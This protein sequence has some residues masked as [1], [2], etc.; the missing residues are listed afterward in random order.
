MNNFEKKFKLKSNDVASRQ[1]SLF[2]DY[3]KKKINKK[4]KNKKVKQTKKRNTIEENKQSCVIIGL[5]TAVLFERDDFRVIVINGKTICG[6]F[7]LFSRWITY[8]L[9][10]KLKPYKGR[11]SWFVEKIEYIDSKLNLSILSSLIDEE[12]TITE[13]EKIEFFNSL[14]ICL[15][16]NEEYEK[17]GNFD[18]EYLF[19]YFNNR[20]FNSLVNVSAYFKCN[21][22]SKLSQLYSE[23]EINRFS[24]TE[25]NDLIQELNLDTFQFCFKGKCPDKFDLNELN[26]EK[27]I[28]AC[29]IFNQEYKQ[30][31]I[32]KIKFYM[33]FKNILNSS[34]DICLGPLIVKKMFEK[35]QLTYK[36]FEG[37]NIITL[38]KHILNNGQPFW[39]LTDDLKKL[40]FIKEKLEKLITS[41]IYKLKSLKSGVIS[42][43]T[44]EQN[45]AH[46]LLKTELNFMLVIG[47]AGVGKTTLGKNIFK[48][49]TTKSCVIALGWQGRLG[50]RLH[51]LYGK[52][53]HIDKCVERIKRKTAKGRKLEED[54]EVIILDEFS[55]IDITLFWKILYY[56]PNLKKLILLGDDKQMPPIRYGAMMKPFMDWFIGTPYL[57][58]LTIN[59]RIDPASKQLQYFLDDIIERN[60]TY[61]R[62]NTWNDLYNHKKSVL[63]LK[64]NN[65]EEDISNIMDYKK[66]SKN[67]DIYKTEKSVPGFQMLTQKNQFKD[68][69]NRHCINYESKNNDDIEEINDEIIDNTTDKKDSDVNSVFFI[70]NQVVF[71]KNTSSEDQPDNKNLKTS[72]VFTG[73]IAVIKS[74]YTIDPSLPLKDQVR[75]AKQYKS[76]SE[77]FDQ[78]KS[79]A[80]I[81]FENGKKINIQFYGLHNLKQGKVI[82]TSSS[83]GE[84][85]EQVCGIIHNNPSNT[86]KK[87]E[88]YTMCSRPKKRLILLCYELRHLVK[89]INNSYKHPNNH[90]QNFLPSY[91]LIRNNLNINYIKSLYKKYEVDLISIC[92]IY[93]DDDDNYDI[94]IDDGFNN[95][96]GENNIESINTIS[97]DNLNNIYDSKH[98]VDTMSSSSDS[99]E[100][101]E[102][103]FYNKKKVD[104][105]IEIIEEKPKQKIKE[106]PLVNFTEFYKTLNKNRC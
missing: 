7:N 46:E 44:N 34:K 19:Q 69:L 37:E 57:I 71:C 10:C 51:L 61:L 88:F 60:T 83:Q 49:V 52:G 96:F 87:E 28:K 77:I 3:P 59:H 41:K 8:K 15:N 70:T 104:K 27:F 56:F 73:E 101:T 21:Q 72:I 38:H 40:N 100:I 58:R 5:V 13:T 45:L 39:Y 76:T 30:T 55:V 12:L 24:V 84:Q 64:I 35:Y 54:I 25:L 1:I 91:E 43:Q 81:L 68:E 105:E 99:N 48:T 79:V 89:I 95:I 32:N 65:L 9:Q 29:N 18:P 75:N 62:F 11:K 22:V 85:F 63:I 23:E 47:D 36:D 14:R 93:D 33:E 86:F 50:H 106:K 16:N 6:N 74:I 78:Y 31:D 102:L 82:T 97:L 98:F 67:I 4:E 53:S 26:C 2:K 90:I 42:E 17:T 20:I 103:N 80:M 66:K 94:E 92:K